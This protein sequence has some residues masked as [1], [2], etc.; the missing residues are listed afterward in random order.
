LNPAGE[1]KVERFGWTFAPG[2][3]VMQIENDYDKEVYGSGSSASLCD[4]S[5]KS[6]L[7]PI[8][9]IL[10]LWCNRRFGPNAELLPLCP[11]E[12]AAAKH[13]LQFLLVFPGS[14]DL[15]LSSPR[16]TPSDPNERIADAE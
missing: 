6:V 4:V 16:P 10:L 1:R 13:P 2:D 11:R 8:A 9:D 15:I 5:D 3:K 14:S 7:H 12:T